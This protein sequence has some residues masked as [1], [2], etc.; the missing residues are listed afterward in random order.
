MK[1]LKQ[2]REIVALVFGIVV[3]GSIGLG[4]RATAEENSKKLDTQDRLLKTLSALVITNTASRETMMTMLGIDPEKA[5][6]WSRMPQEPVTDTLGTPIT[7]VDWVVFDE[8]MQV[9]L[10][11]RFEENT[12]G[13]VLEVFVD[14]LYDVRDL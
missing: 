9:A 4:L 11:Y 5:R 8:D 10:K 3:I 7:G 2:Y 13:K 14:T 6:K 12:D 1:K